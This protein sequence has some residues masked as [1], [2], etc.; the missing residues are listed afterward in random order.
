MTGQPVVD[1]VLAVIAGIFGIIAY[2]SLS[3]CGAGVGLI[4]FGI[5]M[6]VVGLAIFPRGGP[7]ILAMAG[8]LAFMLAV[9]GLV[10]ANGVVSCV[11]I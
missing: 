4:L 11:S 2:H 10:L 9:V 7:V 3:A 8:F 5:T 6:L 1:G